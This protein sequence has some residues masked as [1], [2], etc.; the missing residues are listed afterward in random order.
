MY[1]LGKFLKLQNDEIELIYSFCSRI[2][3]LYLKKIRKPYGYITHITSKKINNSK[4]RFKNEGNYSI[5]YP[6]ISVDVY[7]NKNI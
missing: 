1:L 7:K 2:N 4:D 6:V 5:M 3:L